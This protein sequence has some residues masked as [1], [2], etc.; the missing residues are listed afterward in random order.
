ML[1]TIVLYFF[2]YFNQSKW[3]IRKDIMVYSNVFELNVLRGPWSGRILQLLK[4]LN[5]AFKKRVT[6]IQLGD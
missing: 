2:Q 1:H 4:I 5:G 6:N 3:G